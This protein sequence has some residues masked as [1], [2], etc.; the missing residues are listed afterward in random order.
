[1]IQNV[2]AVIPL[3]SRDLIRLEVEKLIVKSKENLSQVQSVAL[4]EAWKILQ[5]AI[6]RVIQVIETIGSD[7]NGPDKK[8]LAMDLLGNFYDAVFVVVDI[9][10]VPNVLESLLHKYL[11][12]FLMILVSSTIDALVTTFRNTGVFIQRENFQV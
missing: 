10:M 12:A 8:T 5:L 9:P 4:A 1:M 11:K 7:L 6:A 3:T 2:K